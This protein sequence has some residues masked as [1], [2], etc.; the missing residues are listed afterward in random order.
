M[1]GAAGQGRRPGLPKCHVMIQI[2]AIRYYGQKIMGAEPSPIRVNGAHR[3][4]EELAD[5]R[6]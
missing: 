1:E 2:S 6:R 3:A 4:G 5:V